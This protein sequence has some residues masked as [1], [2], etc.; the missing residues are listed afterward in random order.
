MIT[1]EESIRELIG[2]LY[3]NVTGYDGRPT[4]YQVARTDSLGHELRDVI[5]DFQ[6]ITQKDL[7][8]INSGLKKKKMETIVVLSEIDWQNKK[9]ASG[10]A[11]GSAAMQDADDILGNID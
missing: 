1:G 4:D 9:T 10:E 2:E 7:P 3:G 11:A 8:A 5:D 6:K